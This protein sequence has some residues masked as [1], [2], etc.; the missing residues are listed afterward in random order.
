M[1]GPGPVGSVDV[2]STSVVDQVHA[3]EY[4]RELVCDT[5]GQLSLSPAKDG[6]FA[7]RITHADLLAFKS[8]TIGAGGHRDA[9]DRPPRQ[10]ST[11]SMWCWASASSTTGRSTAQAFIDDSGEV[12]SVRRKL[13]PTHVERSVFGEGDGGD[14]QVHDTSL[15]RVGGLCCWEHVQ[16]LTK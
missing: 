7:G 3:F 10:A 11:G 13:K 2:R 14:I 1:H 16:P 6:A 4:W 8:S 5:F 9:A 12:I 15:G